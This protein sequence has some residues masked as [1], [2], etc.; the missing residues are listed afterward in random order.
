METAHGDRETARDE[1]AGEVDSTWKL[2]GLDTD[3]TDQRLAAGL[4]DV[5]HD[6]VGAHARI[7]L[8]VRLQDD[9]DVGPENL[10][11]AAILAE[12]VQGG[13][14][15]RRNMRAQPRDGVAIIVIV[16]RFDE[17]QLKGSTRHDTA[18]R[19][20]LQDQTPRAVHFALLP[21]DGIPTHNALS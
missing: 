2:V 1:L 6:A 3:K 19:G 14:R 15:V 20:L 5:G 21:L 16:R 7:R 9:V 8:V 4:A 10:A 12:A 17:D 13:E 18:H 11:L